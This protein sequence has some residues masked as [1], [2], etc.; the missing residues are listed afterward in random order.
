MCYH[1]ASH[2]WFLLADLV[3]VDG[4]ESSFGTR[5]RPAW[6]F[7]SNFHDVLRKDRER[8]ACLPELKK[9]NVVGSYYRLLAYRN[10]RKEYQKIKRYEEAYT[11]VTAVRFESEHWS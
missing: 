1:L 8:I 4:P 9:E 11:E 2:M 6:V 3:V 10:L 7:Y 5:V